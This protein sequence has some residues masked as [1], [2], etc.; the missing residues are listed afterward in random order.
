MLIE[1]EQAA[2]VLL[3]ALAL[4]GLE[5]VVGHYVLLHGLGRLED[6]LAVPVLAQ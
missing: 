6:A 5:L 1:A 4:V 3:A 2:E